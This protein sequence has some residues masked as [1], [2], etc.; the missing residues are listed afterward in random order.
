MS[1]YQ[2]I[3]QLTNN[4]VFQGRVRSC[5]T[6]EALT[7]QSDERPPISEL[8]NE[9]LRSGGPVMNFVRVI[10]AFPGLS[11]TLPRQPRD[12][13]NGGDEPAPEEPA[14]E[15]PEPEGEDGGGG[16]GLDQSTIPDEAILA[17][18][19]HQW[20]TVAALFWDEDGNRRETEGR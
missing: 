3:D 8:A 11:P 15:E 7:F 9:V 14:P 20:P 12:G 18:V 6:Q 17:Q 16:S 19:Q 1:T 2:Q 13:D 5:C 4:F 10:A